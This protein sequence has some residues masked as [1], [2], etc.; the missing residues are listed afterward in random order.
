MGP[1]RDQ[2]NAQDMLYLIG[3]EVDPAG[4]TAALVFFDPNEPFD[5]EGALFVLLAAGLI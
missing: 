4:R 5:Q 3:L 2:A 1:R